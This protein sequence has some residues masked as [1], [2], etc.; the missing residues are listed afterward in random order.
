MPA[1]IA[2]ILDSRA[3]YLIARILL[4]FVFLS[5]ASI[6]LFDFENSAN[7]MA[8]LGLTPGWAFNAGV[9]TFQICTSLLIIFNRHVWLAAGALAVFTLL[10]IPIAHAFWSKTG[11]DAFRDLRVALEH[12]SL[13][14]GLALVAILSRRG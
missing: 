1:I 8:S 7:R 2:S 14:G 4:A 11:I 12:I 10:T 5:A 13:I 6:K 3:F 9:L